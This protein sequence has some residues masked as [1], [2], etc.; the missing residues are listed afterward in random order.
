MIHS[1]LL[2]ALFA[3]GATEPLT[4]PT[5]SP[6]EPSTLRDSQAG[7]SARFSF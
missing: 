5:Y 4:L 2:P 1:T 7:L 6:I 3:M